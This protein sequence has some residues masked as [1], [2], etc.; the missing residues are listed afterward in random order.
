MRLIKRNVLA[1]VL[2]MAALAGVA[3]STGA[4][5][6]EAVLPVT[7]DHVMTDPCAKVMN[8]PKR[9]VT[10]T[11]VLPPSERGLQ[12]PIEEDSGPISIE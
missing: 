8:W 12:C 7:R 5:A 3:A 6:A 9:S 10:G 2:G 4:A 11:N 1:T